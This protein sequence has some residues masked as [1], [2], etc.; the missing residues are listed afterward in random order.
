[1]PIKFFDYQNRG[2]YHH[3]TYVIID[4]SWISGLDDSRFWLYQYFPIRKIVEIVLKTP[5]YQDLYDTFWEEFYKSVGS[6]GDISDIDENAILLIVETI[7]EQ[8]AKEF[9]SVLGKELGLDFHYYYI[10]HGWLNDN[11]VMLIDIKHSQKQPITCLKS[12]LSDENP[13]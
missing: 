10:F 12:T 9:E 13:L 5:Y 11:Q 1:M 7:A 2:L 8:L 6:P 3:P 4:V